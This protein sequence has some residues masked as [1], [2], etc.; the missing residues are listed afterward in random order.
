M[1]PEDEAR[2]SAA[3]RLLQSGRPTAEGRRWLD[4]LLADPA[5]HVEPGPTA[6]LGRDALLGLIHA[7]PGGVLR[8]HFDPDG[9]SRITWISDGLRALCE[10][11][12]IDLPCDGSQ[13]AERIRLED[14]PALNEQVIAAGIE[15]RPAHFDARITTASGRT[16]WLRAVVAFE[17]PGGDEHDLRY[18]LLARDISGIRQTAEA[19]GRSDAGFRAMLRATRSAFALVDLEHRVLSF[20]DVAV[21]YARNMGWRRPEVG[22]SMFDIVGGPL[23]AYYQRASALVFAGRTV[24]RRMQFTTTAGYGRVLDV[25]LGP[26]AHADGEVFAIAFS[27]MDVSAHVRAEQAVAESDRILAQ[28][29]LGVA[30]VSGDGVVHRWRAAGPRLLDLPPEAVEGR[31]LV[32]LLVQEQQERVAPLVQA[33]LAAGDGLRVEAEAL[34]RDG[35]RVPLEM[36]ITPAG[37]PLEGMCIVVFE[38]VTGRRALQRQVVE[39]HKMEAVGLFAAGLAHD[40]NNL[41]AAIV[42]HTAML[43]LD[44]EPEDPLRAELAGIEAT[45]ERA[46]SLVRSLLGLARQRAD[47]TRTVDLCRLVTGAA[48]LLERVAGLDC[49]VELDVGVD[50][51]PVRADPVQIEQVLVNLV[52]NARDATEGR[53]RIVVRLTEDVLDPARAREREMMPGRAC[54]LDVID[55]GHGMPR[56]VLDRVF[57]PFFSTKPTGRGTGLGLSICRQILRSGGGEIEIDSR[58]GGG[59]RVTLWLPRS[60]EPLP[61]AAEDEQTDHLAGGHE[62]IL[63]VEDVP[64]LRRVWQRL[65]TRLGYRVTTAGDGIEAV[66]LIERGDR[67][68]LLV[69]DVVMPRLGGVAV[70]RRFRSA[71]PEAP[72]LLVSA[73]PGETLDTRSLVDLD[74]ALMRKPVTGPAL[75]R[76]IRLLLSRPEAEDVTA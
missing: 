56:Q 20:N 75:A 4:A 47:G 32:D 25:F 49:T 3:I 41:L 65:L 48:P 31:P 29:P 5:R 10:L 8:G 46:A 74:A 62:R 11:D 16:R 6:P 39:S 76:R 14:H 30:T 38:D 40:F 67:F 68:D 69:S 42:G 22:A 15:G 1:D 57:E 52:V 72:M 26:V 7:L 61:D 73:Y 28:L 59:T 43:D 55:E 63:L 36:A 17:P 34:H 24:E 54:R 64:D 23:R 21:A 44:M 45:T 53:G 71:H 60:P 18:T 66:E 35:T 13:I 50:E 19:L 51:C 37:A 70:A 58:P 9:Q 33:A 27:A 2:I 12:A